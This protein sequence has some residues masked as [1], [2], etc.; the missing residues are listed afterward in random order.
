V[1]S[2]RVVEGSATDVHSGLAQLVVPS[3]AR[4]SGAIADALVS[5]DADEHSRRGA[6]G[7]G[8]VEQLGLLDALMCL[9]TG[10]PV[11]VAD[12]GE[13]GRWHLRGAPAGCVEWLPDGLV[14]RLLVPV[15][16]VQ[17]VLVRATSWRS[18]LRRAAEFEPF[19]SRVVLLE[20]PA[21]KLADV[22]WEADA[23]GVGLWVQQPD[24]Q[25]SELVPPEGFVR[26][27]V[28]PGGWRFTERAYTAW[29]SARNR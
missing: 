18:A 24:G 5:V 25:I 8:G 9:P 27:F 11:P 28:K 7:L 2:I 6:W 17:L 20:R 23:A 13:I 12:L 10:V 26:R 14:R 16:S 3:G 1:V 15:C 4:V 19:A 22:Q 29:I 21:R